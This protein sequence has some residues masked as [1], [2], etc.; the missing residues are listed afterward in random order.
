[1]MKTYKK[2]SDRKKKDMEILTT[3]GGDMT[4]PEN[5]EELYA[6]VWSWGTE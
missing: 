4:S 2:V 5:M 3:G 6:L 1:M